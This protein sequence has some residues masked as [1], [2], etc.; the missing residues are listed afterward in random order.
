VDV[1]GCGGLS[2]HAG[3]LDVACFCD[4]FN[5]KSVGFGGVMVLI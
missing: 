5:L 1:E 4:G 3:L 2:V